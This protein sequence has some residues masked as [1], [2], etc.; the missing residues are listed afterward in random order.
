MCEALPEAGPAD[1]AEDTRAEEDKERHKCCAGE[2]WPLDE[3]PLVHLCFEHD[4]PKD[5]VRQIQEEEGGHE[6]LH[7][8]TH[9]KPTLGSQTVR[10]RRQMIYD[11]DSQI[12][13]KGRSSTQNQH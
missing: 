5:D 2:K 13:S 1:D 7:L 8:A 10:T 4:G 3:G 6:V 9:R 11:L 12:S